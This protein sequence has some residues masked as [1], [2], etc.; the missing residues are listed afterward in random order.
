MSRCRTA[1]DLLASVLLVVFV[2]MPAHDALAD[3]LAKPTG[4]VV[5]TVTGAIS[6]TN[7]PG[8]AEFDQ[9]ML[10]ALGTIE[11]KTRTEWTDGTPTW[12]GVRFSTVLDAVG[13]KGTTVVATALN[14]YSG[15]IGMDVINDYPVL[16]ATSVNGQPLAADKAPIWIIY[17][18]DDYPELLERDDLLWAWQLATVDVR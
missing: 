6:K 15:E 5:L 14:D 9:A 3:P 4:P 7:A 2:A 1:F 8:K 12:Q 17:P 16:L 13:A 10:D 11:V 18:T